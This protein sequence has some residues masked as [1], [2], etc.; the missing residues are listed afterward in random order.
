V[1]ESE[2]AAALEELDRYPA[3]LVAWR[4]LADLGRLQLDRGD[5]RAAQSSF[6]RAAEIVNAC[7][8]NVTDDDLRAT[9]L[10]STAVREVMDGAAHRAVQSE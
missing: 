10:N 2:F 6:N 5:Q 4:T 7:A 9:F 3:P 1:A 8:A